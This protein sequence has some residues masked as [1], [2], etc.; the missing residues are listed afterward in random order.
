MLVTSDSSA[1]IQQS[2]EKL[3]VLWAWKVKSMVPD[4]VVF[5]MVAQ[6]QPENLCPG[7]AL[8][9]FEPEEGEFVAV[10][11]VEDDVLVP[12]SVEPTLGW[13]LEDFLLPFQRTP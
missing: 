7:P 2:V 11:V 5:R 8:E 4:A 1:K 10:V 13:H 6:I 3:E 12:C 9:T